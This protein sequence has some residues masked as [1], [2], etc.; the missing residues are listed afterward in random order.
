MFI[1]NWFSNIYKTKKQHY[2]IRKHLAQRKLTYILSIITVGLQ[3]GWG[4]AN[5]TLGTAEVLLSKAFH[6]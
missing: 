1:V 2:N 3:G 5:D 6:F 4:T